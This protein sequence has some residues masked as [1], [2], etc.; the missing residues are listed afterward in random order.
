MAT[1]RHTAALAGPGTSVV[2]V[3]QWFH[4]PR[5]ILAMRRFGLREVSGNW[6]RWFEARDAY[7]F[8]REAVALPV[9]ALRPVG[10]SERTA[11]TPEP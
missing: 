10:P 11:S 4:L 7:S 1:A 2:V 3:T 8:V 9:Y 6:P 5:A